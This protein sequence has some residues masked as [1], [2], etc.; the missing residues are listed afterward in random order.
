M[1]VQSKSPG[2]A[3]RAEQLLF[4]MAK[5]YRDGN[6]EL[7]PNVVSFSTVIN[8]WAKKSSEE[9]GSAKHAEKVLRLISTRTTLRV[10]GVLS[11]TL[12]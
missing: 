4:N 9:V 7:R 3:L 10:M 8:A 12:F 1:W 6:K 2:S 5:G 11:L